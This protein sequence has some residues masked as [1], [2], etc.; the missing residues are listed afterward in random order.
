MFYI[1][2]SASD[3]FKNYIS[4]LKD[5]NLFDAAKCWDISYIAQ[6][7]SLSP[8]LVI[9]ALFLIAFFFSGRG[10][11]FLYFIRR[12]ISDGKLLLLS[13]LGIAIIAVF[14][15]ISFVLGAL[16]FMI[17]TDRN[18][19]LR[20]TLKV[21]SEENRGNYVAVKYTLDGYTIYEAILKKEDNTFKIVDSKRFVGRSHE[22]RGS[23]KEGE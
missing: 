6:K 15:R 19:L 8:L 12:V 7:V 9:A 10:F 4:L 22:I 2:S 16:Y 13:A 21:L 18:I 11:L 1:S 23:S 14:L 17:E 20:E 3:F 5:G